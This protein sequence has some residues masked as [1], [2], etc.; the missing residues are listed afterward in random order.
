VRKALITGAGPSLEAQIDTIKSERRDGFL[1]ATDT[2]LPALM[3]K[4]IAPDAVLS[5]DCQHISYR[6]FIG[7]LPE[8][9]RL[10]L[11][12]SSPP[13]LAKRTKRLCF[14][15]SPNPFA[16]YVSGHFK[17]MPVLDT[18][19]G[20][21]SHTAISLASELGAEEILLF[22]MDFSYPEGKTY[23]RGTYVYSTFALSETRLASMESLAFSFLL[24]SPNTER[25]KTDSG[26]R[27][28]TPQLS[29]YKNRLEKF[30]CGIDAEIRPAQGKGLRIDVPSRKKGM[31]KP[32]SMMD[33][34]APTMKTEGFLSGLREIIESLPPPDPSI[35]R[36]LSMLSEGEREVVLTLLPVCAYIREHDR[37]EYPL[38]TILS[39]AAQ[40]AVSLLRG[41]D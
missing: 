24:R 18:S 25:T 33:F 15:A 30:L 26:F 38:A 22:G 19:G 36:Y 39:P 23:A 16:R 31:E 40:W 28:E 10:V 41:Q 13:T 14:F 2:S 21:V 1:I 32:K 3:G 34:S 35:T 12:L 37:E 29:G 6:H 7:E 17:G 11:E 20:N 8:D 4:G 27:Y 9:A 5:I